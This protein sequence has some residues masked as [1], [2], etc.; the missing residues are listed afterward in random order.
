LGVFLQKKIKNVMKNKMIIMI[1]AV[2]LMLNISCTDDGY[3][4]QEIKAIGQKNI[5]LIPSNAMEANDLMVIDSLDNNY[6]LQLVEPNGE[7][8]NP[9]P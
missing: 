8:S 7:P 6:N 3:D 1:F 9:K 4:N 2:V 5:K